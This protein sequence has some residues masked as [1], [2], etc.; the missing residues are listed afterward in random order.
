MSKNLVKLILLLLPFSTLAQRPVTEYKDFVKKSDGV[1]GSFKLNEHV[2]VIQTQLDKSKFELAAIDDKMQVVWRTEVQGYAISAGLFRGHILAIAASKYFKYTA[3]STGPYTAFLI[4]EKSGKLLSQKPFL[5]KSAST[6]F[7]NAYF[8][9]DSSGF[10]FLVGR[11]DQ[12]SSPMA[13]R[14][15]IPI[16][17]LSVTRLDNN[18]TPTTS[19][20]KIPG[21]DFLNVAC[22]NAGDIFLFTHADDRSV[23]CTRYDALKLEPQQSIVWQVSESG[24][25]CFF[26]ID[27]LAV[28]STADSNVAYFSLTYLNG[29][30]DREL[31][32]SKFDF[33]SH[34]VT[35][36]GEVFTR[37]HLKEI[38]NAYEPFDRGL[39][40]PDFGPGVAT[41]K[42]MAWW[43]N[44]LVVVTC[45]RDR[46]NGSDRAMVINGY[47]AGLKTKFQQIMP[48][49]SLGDISPMS[50]R[51]EK[52]T[53][54]ILT[55]TSAG[56]NKFNCLYGLLDLSTGKWT[57]LRKLPKVNIDKSDHLDNDVMWF[58]DGF[59]VPYVSA[60]M[61]GS[62]LSLQLN[63]Y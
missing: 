26:C 36:A 35:D 50:V 32:V 62:D 54:Y 30:R 11:S 48:S 25:P 6:E 39:D 12:K 18:L 28:A 53:M 24:V 49:S 13:L 4:D 37:S 44:T 21:E 33:S 55:N 5:D 10:T 14:K 61:F 57:A 19:E 8:N 63:N 17:G 56:G 51:G 59:I 60:G 3:A 16:K 58:A 46:D 15:I 7:A 38:K 41:L 29:N 34:S 23:K 43:N 45:I 2:W 40:K 47:D 31:A 42:H 22:N 9:Q 52:N 20:L 27:D 1:A